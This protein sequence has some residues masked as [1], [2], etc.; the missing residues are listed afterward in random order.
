EE[1]DHLDAEALER[2]FRDLADMLRLAV[3]AGHRLCSLACGVDPEAELGG[4]HHLVAEGR[5]ALADEDF[6]RKRPVDFRRIE[7]V[8]AEF[9]GAVEG[10]DGRLLVLSA[11]G[12]AHAHA[13]KSNRGNGEMRS[14]LSRL[15]AR[16][17]LHNAMR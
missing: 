4:D 12:M 3:D 17:L 5:Q 6:V 10:A 13:A 2:G 14:E 16:V 11:I 1:I 15:H 7:E 8:D 9:D